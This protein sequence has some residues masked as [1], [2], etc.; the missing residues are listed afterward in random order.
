MGHFTM[1]RKESNQIS[2][3]EKL[4]RKEITQVTAA[5][6]L[7]LTSRQVRN[8]A[9]RYRERGPRGLAHLRRGR[10]GNRAWKQEI[11]QEAMMLIKQHYADFGPTFAA[12]KLAQNHHIITNR[13]TLRRAMIK[14]GIWTYRMR[15]SVH[16]KRRERKPIFGMMIQLDGSPHDWFEGRGPSCTLLVFIDDAT[17]KIVWAEFASAESREGVMKA[18]YGYFKK[19]GLPVSFYVDYGS[20]FSVN[21]YNLERDKITQ[22]E[23]AMAELNVEIIH[24]GSPQAKGR[25]E[26][27]NQTLQDRLIKEL[28]LAGISSMDAANQFLHDYYIEHHNAKFSVVAA[29]DQN[30]HRSL[31]GYNLDRILCVKSRRLLANDF[32]ISYQNRILQIAQKQAIVVRPKDS[33]TV[34]TLLDESLVLALRETELNFVELDHKPAKPVRP[35]IYSNI[36]HKPASNHPWRRWAG[37]VKDQ[38]NKSKMEVISGAC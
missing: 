29:Q 35:I 11:C 24:A 6:I 25:V 16:R 17:S 1:S 28:R 36:Y 32:T 18:T 7:H 4:K 31:D 33:I 19:Y 34:L 10:P 14:A 3:F 30:A 27:S 21:L 8:K 2:V 26:R 20:V 22:F 9:K 13:E 15:K 5:R 37:G 38:Q 23:R 12:E